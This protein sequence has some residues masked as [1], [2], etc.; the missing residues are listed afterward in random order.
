MRGPPDPAWG[1]KGETTEATISRACSP[2]APSP[3]VR[4]SASTTAPIEGRPQKRESKP[5]AQKRDEDARIEA[6]VG[7][8][9]RLNN[10]KPHR[11]SEREPLE[12]A[13]LPLVPERIEAVVASRRIASPEAWPRRLTENGGA[14]DFADLPLHVRRDSTRPSTCSKASSRSNAQRVAATAETR[15]ARRRSTRSCAASGRRPFPYGSPVASLRLVAATTTTTGGS[16]RNLRS[17][18][19]TGGRFHSF[20]HGRRL[21]EPAP[22][23]ARTGVPGG[24]TAAGASPTVPV[25][26]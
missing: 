26:R 3:A 10:T 9:K 16:D 12:R 5:R 7:P 6:T 17:G 22:G 14:A 2:S 21:E 13:A 4:S 23:F 15:L 20:S 25:G 8:Y 24:G 1:L 18:R 11:S 19:L